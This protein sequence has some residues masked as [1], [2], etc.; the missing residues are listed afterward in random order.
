M[1]KSPYTWKNSE[2]GP[3]ITCI[4]FENLTSKIL[5]NSDATDYFI[6]LKLFVP[7]QVQV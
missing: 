3:V 4:I 7:L 5:F 6:L 2:Q 1:R